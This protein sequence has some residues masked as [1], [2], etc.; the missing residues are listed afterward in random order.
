MSRKAS[1]SRTRALGSVCGAMAIL[2]MLALSTPTRAGDVRAFFDRKSVYDGDTV[3]LVIE[4]TT[5]SLASPDLSGLGADF[6]LLGTSQS[7]NI[8]IVNGQRTDT[9]RLLVTLAPKGVGVIQVPPI[10]VG[11]DQTDH[12]TLEVREVPEDGTSSAGTDIMVELEIDAE[13]GEL[14]VQQQVPLTV[15]LLTSV[16]LVQGN[17]EDPRVEGALITKLGEDREYSTSRDGRDYRVVERHYTLSP[18]KSGELRFPPLVFEGTVRSDKGRRGGGGGALFN[19]PFFDRFFQ[20]GPVSR[21]PFGMFDRGKPVSAR[22]RAVTLDVKARPGDY[23]GDHWLPAQALEIVDSWT[24]NP[25][26]LRV[27]EPVTRTLTIQAKG[28][29]GPQIP[30]IEIPGGPG[31][32]V[33]PEKTESETRSDGETVY[34]V[35]RQGVT[36][37]PS[38]AGELVIP[39][40]RVTW[41]DTVTQEERVTRVPGWTIKVAGGSGAG[42]A[43]QAAAQPVTQPS[44][45]SDSDGQEPVE[46]PPAIPEANAPPAE[47]DP[48]DL[49]GGGLLLALLLAG[50]WALNRHRRGGR[51]PGPNPQMP[52]ID[53]DGM[54]VHGSE[55]KKAL[56]KA[57]DADDAPGAAKALL[58]WAEAT[59][60]GDA[61]RNLGTL[62]PR[63]VRGADEV[64]AL[65]RRLYAPESGRWGGAALWRALRD[66]LSDADR[67]E[68]AQS[69]VLEPLYPRRT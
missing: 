5:G 6:D 49:A 50:G 39:E 25:P 38:Q 40:I 33:Y 41:W 57:C 13:S 14:L 52:P 60:P 63:L 24:Q 62:V 68:R 64:R 15:R 28:L 22:S 32:R 47:I 26:E 16:P 3:T 61:P 7:T 18:E 46:A 58:A 51:E 56:R 44:A 21:D 12:L 23:A 42:I 11:A 9:V 31:L 65:E 53:R 19:D 43:A 54:R 20:D 67:S 8:S 37:I 1:S 30:E 66:G 17:L 29:S 27:G 34:G 59:W 35:S 45:E 48:R 69:E 10:P 36:S 4:S 2:V 55:A